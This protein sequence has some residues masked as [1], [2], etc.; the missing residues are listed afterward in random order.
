MGLHQHPVF[1][2]RAST[3]YASGNLRL[4][5]SRITGGMMK[6]LPSAL[7]L[8]VLT[9]G[10]LTGA[11]GARAEFPERPVSFIVPFAAGG[12]TDVQTRTILPFVEKHLGTSVVVENRPGAS[13][14]I[15]ATAIVDAEPDGYTIGSL[16]FP[17][18]FAPIHQGIASYVPDAFTPLVNQTLGAICLVVHADSEFTSLPQFV[19]AAKANPG[20]LTLGVTGVGHPSHIAALMFQDAAGFEA[21]YVPFNG[22]GPARTA[23]LGKHITLG[24]LNASELLTAHQQGQV[25]MLAMASDERLPFVPE[26]P[27]FRELGYDVVFGSM[28]GFG[29]P[30]GIPEDALG[31]LVDAFEKASLDPEYLKIAEERQIQLGYIPHQEYVETLARSNERLAEIW[32]THPWAE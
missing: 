12:G 15:G 32:K 11:S 23:L 18:M 1:V 25:R 5:Q 19:E 8:A 31:K 14:L 29:G 10:L 4:T 27:T 21:S 24:M 22:G 6:T 9:I 30:K 20:V 17:S 13:G 28:S 7:A 2:R 16:N 26:V 3:F